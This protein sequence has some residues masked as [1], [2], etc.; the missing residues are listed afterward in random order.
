MF[1]TYM[2]VEIGGGVKGVALLRKGG[3]STRHFGGITRY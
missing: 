3:N 1:V 2:G